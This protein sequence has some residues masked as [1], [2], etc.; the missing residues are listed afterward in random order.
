MRKIGTLNSL[1]KAD[2]FRNYLKGLGVDTGLVEDSELDIWVL[3]DEDQEKALRDFEEFLTN[4]ELPKFKQIEQPRPIVEKKINKKR[5]LESKKYVFQLNMVLIVISLIFFFMLFMDRS[6]FLRLSM[7]YS[8]NLSSFLGDKNFS[9]ILTGQIWRFVT[10]IFIHG[11]LL[12]ILFNLYWLYRLGNEVEE[13]MGSWK[14]L[15]FIVLVSACSNTAYY[16]VAGP[17]FGG[18]S[19]LIYALVGFL[20]SLEKS[21]PKV[22]YKDVD[23]SIFI[24]FTVWYVSS[25]VLTGAGFAKIANTIHAVGA[26][27]GILFGAYVGG[28]FGVVRRIRWNRENIYNFFIIVA[29]LFGSVC[30]DLLIA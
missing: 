7:L 4:P 28:G 6:G 14:Y 24:F 13:R 19:G 27:V 17:N 21:D 5:T 22:Y 29:L 26:L 23:R 9:E 16:V 15:I 20:W 2:I 25:W 10:P 12:H 8:A 11:D 30:V 3:D 18:L 1:D